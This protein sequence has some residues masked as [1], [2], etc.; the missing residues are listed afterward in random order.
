[1]TEAR[2]VKV[3]YI[4]GF[5][6]SGSTLLA[7][8]LETIDGFCSVGELKF[9]WQ[10]GLARDESC[11]C[12]SRF[13]ECTFW[14]RV[15]DEAFGGWRAIDVDQVLALR[16]R[17]VRHRS[18]AA[19]LASPRGTYGQELAA[20]AGLTGRLVHAIR[21]VSGCEV[22][23]D[24]SKLPLEVLLLRRAPAVEPSVIHLVRDS[25]GVAYS[26][27]KR[28]LVRSGAAEPTEYMSA[29]G[30]VH[31]ATR[32]VFY[33]G[34]FDGLRLAGVP[35]VRTRY[36]D[37]VESPRREVARA[38]DG[39]RLGVGEADLDRIGGADVETAGAHQI[40]GNPMRFRGRQPIRL[41]REWRT[42][43]RVSDRRVVSLLTWPLLVGYRYRLTTG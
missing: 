19:M 27:Q 17:V 11:S 35:V 30:P 14:Q 13:S 16:S 26:W 34:F 8:L 43:M 23:V 33:N 41:D 38:L 28:S 15:G 6:R 10:R 18:V 37:L 3:L 2:P 21:A 40:S 22:I 42:K 39:L 25:R 1:M 7:H 20:Y 4:G 31:T 24:S 9:V 5:G 29:Y 32:W 12:G 36:E